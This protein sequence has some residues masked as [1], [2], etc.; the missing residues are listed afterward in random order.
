MRYEVV[1]CISEELGYGRIPLAEWVGR[2]AETG[3]QS[4]SRL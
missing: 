3:L 1:Y 4:L 2:V